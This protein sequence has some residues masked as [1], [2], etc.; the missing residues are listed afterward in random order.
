MPPMGTHV[1]AYGIHVSSAST[2]SPNALVMLVSVLPIPAS[3]H[4]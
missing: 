1:V 3:R 2:M 4:A